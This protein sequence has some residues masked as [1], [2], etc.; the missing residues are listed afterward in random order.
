MKMKVMPANFVPFGAWG[1]SFI[2]TPVARG[3]SI[4]FLFTGSQ[5]N[6]DTLR[7]FLFGREEPF[8]IAADCATEN[9]PTVPSSRPI[10]LLFV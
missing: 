8:Q 9:F 2:L 6:G 3:R 4:R 7:E 1:S 5:T 10:L